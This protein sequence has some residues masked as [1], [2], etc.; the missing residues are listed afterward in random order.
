MI[1]FSDLE[2]MFLLKVGVEYN[3]IKGGILES[4]QATV[5]AVA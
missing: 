4:F 5:E 3:C 1:V 2:R